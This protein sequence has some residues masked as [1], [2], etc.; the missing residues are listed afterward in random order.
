MRAI[1]T[2]HSVD[3]SGSPI[4]V[5]PATF[6]EHTAFLASGRVRVTDLAGVLATPADE[7]AIAITFDDGFANFADRAWPRLSAHGLPVTV[8]V[9][10]DHAGRTNAWGGRDQPGI[11]TLPLL[12]WDTLAR[13][14][15]EGVSLGAHSRT[16][17]DLTRADD[18]AL[19]EELDRS[20]A[21]IEARTGR[22]P[23]CF[24]Y[25]FGAHDA[26]VVQRTQARYDYAC[27][28]ELRPLAA[29]VDPHRLPRLD[30]YYLRGAGL[31]GRWGTPPFAR[32]LRLR[33]A[34]RA[35]RDVL[36]GR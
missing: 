16:H 20:A 27:T 24:A 28:T 9:V 7:D 25:P 6:D 2:Y 8:F 35:M 1:L 19:T 21:G 5:S 10:S 4:S 22:R 17:R 32:Y 36:T 13:L 31:L 33:R 15:E 34:A 12:D 30:A 18:A 29:A 3:D 26:R 11:P 23:G 14:A